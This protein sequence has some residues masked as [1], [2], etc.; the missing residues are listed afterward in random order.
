MELASS[1]GWDRAVTLQ[2]AGRDVHN[3]VHGVLASSTGLILLRKQ[4]LVLEKSKD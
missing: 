4:I 2:E 1:E 3:V